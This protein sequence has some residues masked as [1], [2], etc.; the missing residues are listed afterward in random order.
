MQP[1]K[2]T[3]KDKILST[4]EDKE[5]MKFTAGEIKEMVANRFPNTN[6]DSVMPADY[7][8]NITNKGNH[9]NLPFPLFESQQ[10]G[11]YKYLGQNFQY[12]GEVYWKGV[13]IGEWK[14]GVYYQ[15]RDI[16]NIIRLSSNKR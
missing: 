6:K 8:Y 4:F 16:N 5:G 15:T 9:L 7:C 2:I 10:D 12:D 1:G 13:R 11:T 14:H 3:I